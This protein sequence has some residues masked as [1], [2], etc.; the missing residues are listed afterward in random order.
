MFVVVL[1]PPVFETNLTI[2]PEG[3]VLSDTVISEG[4]QKDVLPAGIL[5]DFNKLGPICLCRQLL[6]NRVGV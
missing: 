1:F 3:Q 6:L 5:E 4:W 2:N